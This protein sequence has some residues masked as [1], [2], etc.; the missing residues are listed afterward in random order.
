MALIRSVELRHTPNYVDRTPHRYSIHQHLRKCGGDLDDGFGNCAWQV[1]RE[2]R[3]PRKAE[4]RVY[5]D[6]DP[7]H[8]NQNVKNDGSFGSGRYSL[9]GPEKADAKRVAERISTMS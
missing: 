5:E 3:R 1:R 9:D 4:S 8:T 6:K 7:K 2:K